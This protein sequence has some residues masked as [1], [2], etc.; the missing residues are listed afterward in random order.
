MA[1][2]D[3][4]GEQLA[5]WGT[6][7]LLETRGRVTGSPARAAVGYVEEEDGSLLVAAGS[8]QAAWALNLLAHPPCHVTIGDRRGEFDSEELAGRDRNRAVTALIL[9]YGTPAEGLGAGPAFRLRPR[10][11]SADSNAR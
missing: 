11:S 3:P 9:K 1:R 8:P 5:G 4:V 7:A 2:S 6:V 10:S